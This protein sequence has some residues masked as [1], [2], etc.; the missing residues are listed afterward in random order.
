MT[1]H[2]IASLTASGTSQ[3]KFTNIPQTYTHLQIRAYTRSA[4]AVS[5]S[6]MGMQFN[7]DGGANYSFGWHYIYGSG[8]SA[9]SGHGGGTG[10]PTS[11]IVNQPG[12]STSSNIFASAVVDIFDYTNTSKNKTFK[13]IGG[14]D[15]NGS[16]FVSIGS[17]LWLSTAAITAITINDSTS[18]YLPASNARYDL[19]G[20][21]TNPIATGA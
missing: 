4:G 12:T 17:G 5:N 19:Y 20:I 2:H 9:V 18:P 16:G 14:Y 3:P 11:Y 15:A 7:E 1:M 6:S 8:A 21:T 10:Y 13:A